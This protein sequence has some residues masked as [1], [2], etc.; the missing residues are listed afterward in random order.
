MKGLAILMIATLLTSVVAFAGSMEMAFGG[1]PT[2]ISL[3]SINASI[4]VFN[5][6][7]AHLNETFAVHPD[8]SGAIDPIAPMTSGLSFRAEERFWLLD[9]FGLGAAIE[10]YSSSTE[11]IGFYEGSEISTIDVALGVTAVGALL[12]ARASFLD[13][14]LRLAAE[15][16]F[17]Y[18]YVLLDRSTIFE[19]P[20]EYPDA[21]SGVPPDGDE[22][23]T[24]SS[25]GFE[26]GL[27]LSYP[28][29]QWL[30]I[31]STVTYRSATVNSVANS[32]GDELDLDGDGTTEPIDL[33]GITVRLVLSLNID[34]SPNGEK[35]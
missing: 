30:S 27:N 11:T 26:V 23:F 8:V 31:G 12:G 1:G 24:G 10:Y 18:Y 16:G 4:G 21:I 33:D 15:G 22:R 3:A 32:A 25:L 6:L 35:E 2:A 9:W 28:M 34:L 14:G 7:I 19:I 17:G 13:A 5:T 29:T 20:I